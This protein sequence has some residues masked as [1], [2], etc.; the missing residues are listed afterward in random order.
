MK[1]AGG[2][3][4]SALVVLVV[5][6]AVWLYRRRSKRLQVLMDHRFAE[7]ECAFA[8]VHDGLLQDVQGLTLSL[9]AIA[10]QMPPD[11]PARLQLEHALDQAD[12]L[13]ARGRERVLGAGC[14]GKVPD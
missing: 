5:L 8:E 3:L 13:L 1:D 2:F 9:Q 4:G 11:A 6:A 10:E 12:E 7:R 14:A